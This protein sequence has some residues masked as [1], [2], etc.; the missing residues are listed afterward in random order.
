MTQRFTSDDDNEH[1]ARLTRLYAAMGIDTTDPAVQA[2]IE[3]IDADRLPN[4]WSDAMPAIDPNHPLI[5]LERAYT[6]RETRA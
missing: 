6:Q 3:E 5:Q 1:S 4:H 2:L